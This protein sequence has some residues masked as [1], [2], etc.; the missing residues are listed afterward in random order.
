MQV[1]R[2]G[3]QWR[4]QRMGRFVVL[5]MHGRYSQLFTPVSWE[6]SHWTDVDILAHEA[7]C[8]VSGRYD[9]LHTSL[10]KRQCETIPECNAR[11][12]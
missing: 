4:I 10:V 11:Y 3:R 8:I 12:N 9:R 6:Y 2:R 5:F 7:E 1:I